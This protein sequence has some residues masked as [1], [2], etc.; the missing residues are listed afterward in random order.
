MGILDNGNQQPSIPLPE[1]VASRIRNQTRQTYIM[2]VNA[3]NEG[4]KI[5]W[6]NP[7]GVPPTEIAMALDKDA[8]EIFELH[9]KLAQLLLT[10][11][12]EDI[13]EGLA[14]VGNFSYNEDGTVTVEPPATEPPELGQ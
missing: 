9:G 12:P 11:K 6:Q 3:F 7:R 5:F 10:I 4:A 13:S 1:M 8:R 14:V 2:M